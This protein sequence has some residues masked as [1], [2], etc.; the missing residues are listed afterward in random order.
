[1]A[2]HLLPTMEREW[3]RAFRHCLL[4][5]SPREVLASYLRAR[6][7]A[8]LADLGFELQCDIMDYI[9]R[10]LDQV[11]IVIDSRD[12]L[13]APGKL[14]PKLCEA[15]EIDYRPTMLAWSPGSR[16]TDGVWAKHW[17]GSVETS[18]GFS[19]YVAKPCVIPEAFQGVLKAAEP[20]YQRLYQARIR[21]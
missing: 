1:M 13:E 21:P 14:L 6:G 19:P 12:V 3:M 18:T 7:T 11:P 16:E 4:I 17:Y 5:R 9:R 2:H 10:E 15:L 8:V 20:L